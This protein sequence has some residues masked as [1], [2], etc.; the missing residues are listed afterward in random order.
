MQRQCR[1]EIAG[2]LPAGLGEELE[3][4]FG[5]M[6]VHAGARTTALTG[7]PLDQ[8]G[9]RA[10]LGLLWDAGVEV[11]AVRTAGAPPDHVVRHPVA[12][13]PPEGASPR[14]ST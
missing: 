13:A 14:R 11:S 8:A 3:R 6:D 9:L 1:I 12:D 7:P 10:L 2:R 5:P 4:R